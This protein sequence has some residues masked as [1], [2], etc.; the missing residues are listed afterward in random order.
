ME[1]RNSLECGIYGDVVLYEDPC[2]GSTSVVYNNG[3]LYPKY[4]EDGM[5]L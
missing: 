3:I 1:G 2:I 4:N 5:Y